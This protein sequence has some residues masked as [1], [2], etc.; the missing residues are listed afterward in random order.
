MTA[1]GAHALYGWMADSPA[2]L[3]RAWGLSDPKRSTRKSLSESCWFLLT[4]YS[5]RSNPVHDGR[6]RGVWGA[7]SQSAGSDLN[8]PVDNFFRGCVAG[9][10]VTYPEVRYQGAIKPL[11]PL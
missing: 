1:K 11:T 6:R 8:P 9:A 3:V 5:S 7:L 10:C 4:V 2:P